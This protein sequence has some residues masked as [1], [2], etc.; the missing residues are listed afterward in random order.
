MM[1]NNKFNHREEKQ[2]KKKFMETGEFSG[3]FHFTD[4]SADWVTRTIRQQI[5]GK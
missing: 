2:R 4:L 5:D 1:K 3:G